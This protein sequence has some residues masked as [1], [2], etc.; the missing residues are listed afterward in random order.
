[1]SLTPLSALTNTGLIDSG[2]TVKP[3]KLHA[4]AQQFEALVIGE[5]MRSQREA[6]SEGWMGS[7]GGTGDD[8]AMDMAEAQ[9]SNA[10][11]AGGGLG[12]A[13]MIEKTMGHADTARPLNVS[14]S[15]K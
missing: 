1:M 9:F 10:L 8:S 15:T 2:N 6:G 13:K 5:M 7:G 11:A 3:S 4:A 14:V 12:L